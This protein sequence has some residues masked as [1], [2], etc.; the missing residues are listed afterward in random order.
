MN[1]LKKRIILWVLSICLILDVAYIAYNLKNELG[2]NGLMVAILFLGLI[3][4]AIIVY[5]INGDKRA[6]EPTR[7]TE[8]SHTVLQSMQRVFKIVTAEGVFNEIYDYQETKKLWSILPSTKKALVIVKG[9]AHMGYDFSKCKWDIDENKRTV[10]LIEFPKPELLS[11]D[12][13]FE[14]YNME[15]KFYDLFKKEDLANIQREGK[16]QLVKAAYKSQLPQTAAEQIKAV[17]TE[18]LEAKGWQ[19]ENAQIITD[20]SRLID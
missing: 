9:K 14:Y 13:D 16:K 6:A 11:M 15:E 3:V 8:S 17:V 2:Q 1:Y 18:L 10:K 12:T 7:I 4:G 19:L 5:I 20:S